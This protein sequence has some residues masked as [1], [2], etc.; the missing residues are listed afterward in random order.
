M[1]DEFD[2]LLKICRAT[3]TQRR[4]FRLFAVWCA[5]RVQSMMPDQSGMDALDAA[6][7]FSNGLATQDELRW[8]WIAA[9]SSAEAATEA[10]RGALARGNAAEE[11]RAAQA[12]EAATETVRAARDVE[13]MVR[14]V[15]TTA[16]LT[17]QAAAWDATG[18]AP[19]NAP[20]QAGWKA[21][22]NAAYNAELSAHK[23]ELRRVLACL[24]NVV[25]PYPY[26]QDT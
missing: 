21:A 7:R 17:S 20:R 3:E 13:V 6:E 1:T 10:V 12:A 26:K 5:R 16:W 9:K 8:A 4:A 2:E 19:K 22:W 14:A 23:A 18:F 24:T 11:R 25:D 15:A